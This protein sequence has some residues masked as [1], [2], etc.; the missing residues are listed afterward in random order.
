MFGFP[1]P[2][3]GSAGIGRAAGDDAG[4][5]P[6]ENGGDGGSGAGA[7]SAAAGVAG[8]QLGGMP[9]QCGTDAAVAASADDAGSV[10]VEAAVLEL[11]YLSDRPAS[12]EDA[13]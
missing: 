9:Q 6:I 12:P 3:G 11:P 2:F 5:D 10:G 13:V 7:T 1:S 8:E 4:T